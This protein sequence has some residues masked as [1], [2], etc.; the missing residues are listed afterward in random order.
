MGKI[1]GFDFGSAYTSFCVQESTDIKSVPSVITI[2]K[3]ATRIIASGN[4]ARSMIGRAPSALEVIKPFKD[5]VI[6]NVDATT[7]LLT[8]ILDRV[9]KASIFNRTEIIAT[10][11]FGVDKEE[12]ELANAIYDTGVA[13]LRLV[14]TPIAI[15]LGAGM[16]AD[17]H[18]GRMIVD[19]GAGHTDAAIISHGDVVL[20]SIIKTA[21]NSMTEAVK[22]YVLEAHGIEIGELTAEAIKLKIGTL[23]PQ[24]PVKS[25]KIFGK[26][27]ADKKSDHKKITAGAVITSTELVPVLTPHANVIVSNIVNA[28][29]SMPT[30]IASDVS[31]FGLLLSGGGAALNGFPEYIQNKLRIKVTTTKTPQADAARGLLRI[32]EGGRAF[33]K[34]ARQK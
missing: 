20:S 3:K 1:I 14:H 26:V 21:G 34:F 19:I 18:A 30:E 22:T 2:D 16:P 25:V 10:V 9:E 4:E 7:L 11:P 24:A 28:L 29:K 23:N 12:R 33:A 15:A 32:S 5:G 6:D 8:E 17:L 13:S 31:N 27:R